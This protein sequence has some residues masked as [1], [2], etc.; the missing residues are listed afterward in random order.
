MKTYFQHGQK[1]CEINIDII[2]EHVGLN[3]DNRGKNNQI[4]KDIFVLLRQLG[5]IEYHIEKDFDV[6]SG[7]YKT[8]YILDKVD[9]K[10]DFT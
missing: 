4:I 8:K 2:K 9:N 7:G 6:V 3:V 5:F 1:P 10:V